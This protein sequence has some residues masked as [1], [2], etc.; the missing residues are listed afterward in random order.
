MYQVPRT[1]TTKTT[2]DTRDEAA[3]ILVILQIQP[4]ILLGAS[5]LTHTLSNLSSPQSRFLPHIFELAPPLHPH[6]IRWRGNQSTCV[7]QGPATSSL[8]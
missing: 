6:G 7:D 8:V 5:L 3:E 4:N 1:T 2:D